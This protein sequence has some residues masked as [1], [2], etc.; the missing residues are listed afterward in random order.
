[1]NKARFFSLFF[2]LFLLGGTQLYA[3][4]RTDAKCKHL[5]SADC[6]EKSTHKVKNFKT[7]DYLIS[8]TVKKGKV[9]R[10]RARHATTGKRVIVSGN[11]TGP[12]IPDICYTFQRQHCYR[13]NGHCFCICGAYVWPGAVD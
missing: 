5:V 1:M 2:L 10:I 8:Y 6:C 9:R 3:Q 4:Q 12:C 11:V 13:I 7:G